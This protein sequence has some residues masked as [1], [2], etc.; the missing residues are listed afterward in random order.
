MP[1]YGPEDNLSDTPAAAPAE[2]EEASESPRA[3][4]PKSILMGKEAKPGDRL[5]LK[6]E[7][8]HDDEIEVSYPTEKEEEPG[9]AEEPMP[10]GGGNAE[11]Q[12]MME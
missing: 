3:L 2:K 8:V 6:I 5:L 10:S 7:A 9:N 4:L 12:G 1:I 11:M